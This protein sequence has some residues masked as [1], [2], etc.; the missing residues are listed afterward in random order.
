[1]G[2]CRRLET[3]GRCPPEDFPLQYLGHRACGNCRGTAAEPPPAA[4]DRWKYFIVP[5]HWKGGSISNFIRTDDGRALEQW[6]GKKIVSNVHHAW[7]R[8]TVD[9]PETLRDKALFLT[10]ERIDEG[11]EI[12]LNGKTLA[13]VRPMPPERVRIPVNDIV[14]FGELNEILVRVDSPGLRNKS[15]GGLMGAVW[16]E[17][18]PKNNIGEP[19]IR[20]LLGERKLKVDFHDV[21]NISGGTLRLALR[22]AAD[23]KVVL[24]REIPWSES[25][26]ID[27]EAP[28]LWSP[29]SP[30]LYY[31]DFEWRDAEGKLTDRCSR[32]FGFREFRVSGKNFLLNGS[33]VL[34]RADTDLMKI[35][36]TTDWYMNPEHARREFRLM[37]Q[38]RINT[39]YINNSQPEALA[40]VA[41]EEGILLL[42][43]HTYPY[44]F[45]EKSSDETILEMLEE[46]LRR[47]K[48]E[49]KFYNHPSRIA[50]LI[51]VWFNFHNGA[52]NGEYVGLKYGTKSYPAFSADGRIVA[53]SNP[54]PN[55]AQ[56]MR[57]AR[58]KRLN[59]MAE[60]FRKY[61][62]D[63]AAFT[64]GS[65]EVD[66]IYSTH[67][68][69][70]WGAPHEELRAL[71]S[72]YT[73]QPELPIFIGEHNIPYAG[74]Y[75]PLAQ[76][77]SPMAGNTP[78]FMENAARDAGHRVYRF[79]P[80]HTHRPLHGWGA[81]SL[82][83][84]IHDKDPWHSYSLYS[85]LY[86]D[87]LIRNI[88]ALIPAWRACG[89]NGFG[90][91][92]YVYN[93]FLQAGHRIP[94]YGT[95][96][97]DISTPFFKP[98]VLAGGKAPWGLIH[99]VRIRTSVRLMPQSRFCKQWMTP[100]AAF[101]RTAKTSS[102]RIM[103]ISPAPSSL[104]RCW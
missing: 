13:T 15:K 74:S 5:G 33:P 46:Q 23:N 72:Q 22:D 27:C 3:N 32:R 65:G 7:Y 90:M 62:P 18:L 73:L 57:L 97:G 29:D 56:P 20:T 93:N 104:K 24:I 101:S 100:S 82:Q 55:L 2:I 91:F 85:P 89:V 99:S 41:D 35:V 52:T 1:M 61:F 95:I 80:V 19:E 28:K 17:T 36:W 69:H 50:W 4:P 31:L 34:L 43:M 78:L 11:G 6:N 76:P 8:R 86:L 87:A 39:L 10:F 12:R 70:T 96:S 37:K 102:S 38:F 58:M 66:S 67:I 26:S 84:G 103:R 71:F 45:L 9:I 98:E 54:D 16:L 88:E 42:T 14:K 94:S 49:K 21:S 40:D 25:V 81:G 47:I 48:K 83:D 77:Y 79:P 44:K 51:D 68:Y 59:R 30:N 64:G 53:K 92:G 63:M 75:Y 60:L